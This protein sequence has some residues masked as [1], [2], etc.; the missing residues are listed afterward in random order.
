M[1]ISPKAMSRLL[2]VA[3]AASGASSLAFEVTWTRTLASVMGSS[4]YALSTML[5]AFMAGLCLGG[6]AGAAVSERA[7]NLVVAFALCELGIGAL[8]LVVTPLIRSLTPL[9]IASYYAF[10]ASFVAFSLVQFLIAFLVMAVPT[11]LMGMTFPIAVKL[12]AS[13]NGSVGRE[14]GRV[15]SVNTLGGILGSLAAGFVLIPLVGVSRTAAVA[16]SLDL[17]LAVAILGL[18][19]RDRRVV[20]AVAGAAIAVIVAAALP[21]RGAPSFA[22]AYASRFASPELARR[23]A[24]AAE[25][26]EVLFHD[27]GVEGDV[28]LLRNSRDPRHPPALVNGGKLEGG[29]DVSFALL[30]QLPYFTG[31]LI[32]PVRTALSI[33]LGSGRTLAR[34]AELP[35]EAIDSVEINPGVI[36]AN[37]RFLSPGLFSDA[38]VRHVVAD[39][40]NHLLVT[41]RDYDLIVV[42][43]S[44]A[45]DVASAGLLTDDFFSLAA[46][47][48]GRDGVIGVWVDFSMMSDA[49]M[50]RLLR[51]F[52]KSF[53]HFTAWHVP[54]GNV[55]LV[56]SVAEGYAD[57]AVV[58]RL[59]LRTTPAAAAGLEV[60][61]GD[62]T[63]RASSFEDINT[64]DRPI[65]E[66]HNAR[67]Y[68]T[69]PGW[70]MAPPAASLVQ[71]PPR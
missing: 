58:A 44:W 23:V 15:Y 60:G 40:R 18:S 54:G 43:P 34:L 56:G 6:V 13:W 46:R 55:V 63:R 3:V 7:R 42:S 32:A 2:L 52:Q 64:D 70:A 39:G 31:R 1:S 71:S 20:G 9:Y 36:E 5:A 17:A 57:E 59:A 67:S 48:L 65:L 10:H 19:R 38:R 69:G 61:L 68:V 28:W 14:A 47:R 26:T 53:R 51:T 41:Q 66:F 35:L 11:T 21:A 37:R 24:A 30:G 45:T 49:D 16:A 29:D 27:E 8:G 22:F 4:T 25:E 33:G 50:T 62:A 12:F